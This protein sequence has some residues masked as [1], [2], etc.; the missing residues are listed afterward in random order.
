MFEPDFIGPLGFFVIC[1][2]IVKLILDYR[3]K[4]R[5]LDKGEIDKNVTALFFN[6]AEYLAPT[7]LKWGLVLIGLGLAIIIGQMLPYDYDRGEITFSL[8]LLFAGIGL[9]IYYAVANQ[10][11]KEM[12]KNGKFNSPSPPNV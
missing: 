12:K 1:G 8:M 9:L 5:L 2:F 10:K 6:K 3:L 4:R 11:L 7:S